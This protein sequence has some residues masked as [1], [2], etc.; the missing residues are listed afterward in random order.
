MVMYILLLCGQCRCANRETLGKHAMHFLA[1]Y[2]SMFS[3]QGPFSDRY[4][5]VCC[6]LYSS[7]GFS[8]SYFNGCILLYSCGAGR[9]VYGIQ[10]VHLDQNLTPLGYYSH[11]TKDFLASNLDDRH[12]CCDL[13]VRDENWRALDLCRQTGL[14][15][16]LCFPPG[17]SLLLYLCIY[18]EGNILPKKDLQCTF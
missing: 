9:L 3:R 18:F 7:L 2:I 1:G 6:L 12:P 13:P 17:L 11:R 10:Q 14:V 15:K 8:F 16:K 4:N 5:T